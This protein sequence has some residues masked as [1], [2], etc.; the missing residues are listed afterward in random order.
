M[1]PAGAAPAVLASPAAAGPAARPWRAGCAAARLQAALGRRLLPPPRL[2]RRGCQA[3]RCGG[4]QPEGCGDAAERRRGGRS[5]DAGAAAGAGGAGL[6]T[7][8]APL[9]SAGLISRIWGD[10]P[11]N[12]GPI[13]Y[14]QFMEYLV[15]KR[16]L[17]LL[18]Y[19]NG[20]NAIGAR[21]AAA[22]RA[23]LRGG[24]GCAA[25]GA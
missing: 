21:R 15:N 4:R 19:D 1:R 24:R 3:V 14:A 23:Q 9:A 16:V 7:L 22:P 17:R 20:K 5:G 11:Q 8:G 13:N 6:G 12:D 2:P 25:R 10:R 18:I